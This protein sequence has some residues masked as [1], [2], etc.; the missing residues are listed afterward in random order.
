ML[1]LTSL[2][3]LGV[4]TLR[5]DGL[6]VTVRSTMR[7]LARR[8]VMRGN[9]YFEQDARHFRDIDLSAYA[10]SRGGDFDVVL[11]TDLRFAGGSGQSSV[12]ELDIQARHGLRSGVYH[13]ASPL[14]P[15]AT[16]VAPA[17]DG[18]LRQTGVEVLNTAQT[19][20]RT[21][22]LI[23]R[24]PTILNPGGDD[25]PAITADHLC[26]IVN[27]PPVQFDRIQYLLTDARRK[28]RA[29]YGVQPQIHPIGPLIRAE[30]DA[31]YDGSVDL[32]QPDWVN[33]F[34]I[35]RFAT[36][37]RAPDPARPLRIGRHSRMDPEKWPA[38]AATIRAAYPD[39]PD[40]SVHILGGADVPARI[41][42]GVPSNWTVHA[43]GSI[44]PADF[45]RDIDVFVYFHHPDW[46]E[47]FGRVI[48]EAMAA[49]LPVVVPP[50]FEPL[51]GEAGIYCA[52]GDVA[53]QLTQLRDPAYYTHKS[54]L[55]RDMAMRRFSTQVHI[56]RLTTI[57]HPPSAP[58]R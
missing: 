4:D 34:D 55:C 31:V 28:L 18:L 25:L 20:I 19:P 22:L 48:V 11:V 13:M 5:R 39:R 51:L 38:D 9:R 12:Q 27:H 45:L 42:G 26:L 58:V 57:C 30:I 1:G 16:R 54:Q 15:H 6:A 50:H 43:F 7:Y 21:K 40:I 41:L 17:M 2:I 56:D 47:A 33:V 52:P 29:A 46:I 44:D 3:R 24:H 37:R 14:I 35:A 49:G 53:D 8:A 10:P 36:P 23:F 32:A